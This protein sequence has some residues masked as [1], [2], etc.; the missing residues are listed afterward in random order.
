[1]TKTLDTK[2]VEHALWRFTHKLG[3]YGCFEVTLGLGMTR[4]HKE[5]VDYITYDKTGVVRCY[6]RIIPTY[7]GNT[8][9]KGCSN[10]V[11][12]FSKPHFQLV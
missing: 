6:E 4:D 7:V 10:A 9:K 8:L 5:I 1:M 12:K 2:N 3:V 11:L